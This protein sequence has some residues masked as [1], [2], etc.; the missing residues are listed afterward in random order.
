[1]NRG[2]LRDLI[3]SPVTL[4]T[5][6]FHYRHILFQ[7]VLRDIQGRFAGSIGGFLWNFIHPVLML[8]TYL[9]VFVYIF[10][11]R[12]A[13]HSGSG[14]SAVYI[15]AGLF[16][17]MIMAEG[18]MRGTTS[19]AENAN[20][21]KKTSFPIEI[22]PAKAILAAL[23]TNGIALLLLAL[24]KII[25]S[26]NFGIMLVLPFVVL[27]QLLFTAGIVFLTST[28]SVF[29]R[30]VIQLMQV[31][32][33]FWAYLTPV[34]YTMTMLPGWA[35]KLM[36]LNPLYPI[37]AIYQSLLVGNSLPGWNIIILAVFW[38]SLFFLTGAF[39][40][41]KLKYEFADWL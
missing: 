28:L 41:T 15:M 5:N 16:P 7:M 36:A 19:L 31:L 4:T 8:I 32:V 10:K 3:L 26:G 2:Y 38:T 27:L 29:F 14:A 20:L 37:I 34:L 25:F 22:L 13:S 21:I 33:N 40:F 6:F 17:W 9:V 18:F 12:V 30:D 23:M 1:M 24:Y 39:I 11:L 35:Q